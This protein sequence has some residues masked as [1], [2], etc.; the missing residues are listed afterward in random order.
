ML[1]IR[2]LII[3]WL[4]SLCWNRGMA[5]E[6]VVTFS[7]RNMP[8]EQV[9]LLLEKQTSLQ[10]SFESSL[11][12]QMR[13]VTLSVKKQTLSVC[14]YELFQGYDIEW[15]VT[16]SYLILKRRRLV[17]YSPKD[18][19][20]M[21]SLQEFVVEA[22]SLKRSLALTDEPGKEL[23]SGNQIR[24]LP[25]FMGQPDFTASSGCRD[26]YGRNFRYVCAGRE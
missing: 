19:I 22:D 6:P 18:S 3:L 13:P 23:L 16:D 1:R 26:W 20:K 25:V 11:L 8:I 24:R 10:V 14:L 5:T 9:L 12:E 15:Q 7:V 17:D 2:T 21:V 4:V